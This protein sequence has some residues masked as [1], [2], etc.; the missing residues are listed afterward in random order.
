MK[1]VNFQSPTPN[2][3]ENGRRC[4]CCYRVKLRSV[5]ASRNERDDRGDHDPEML[6]SRPSRPS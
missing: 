1:G 5:A 2:C 3:A 4:V 6:T